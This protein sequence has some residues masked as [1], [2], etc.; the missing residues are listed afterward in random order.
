MRR[1]ILIASGALGAASL[2]AGGAAWPR[3]GA[4]SSLRP[5]HAGA[6]E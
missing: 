4:T 6:G 5:E 2:T 1:S 3:V